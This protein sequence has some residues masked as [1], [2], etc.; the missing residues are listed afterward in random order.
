MGSDCRERRS[1]LFSMTRLL[2]HRWLAMSDSLLIIFAGILLLPTILPMLSV[3]WWWVR[4]WDFPR[5]QLAVLYVVVMVLT[6]ALAGRGWARLAVLGTLAMGILYQFS[7]IFPYLPFAS[8]QTQDATITD[9]DFSIRILTANVLMTNRSSQKFLEIVGRA[10][11]DLLIIDEPDAWWAEQLRVL[12]E[13]F[14]YS[15]KHP[16]DNT[17]GMIVYS[18]LPMLRSEVRFLLDKEIPSIHS[19]LRLRSGN[20]IEVIAVHPRPPLPSID[21]GE[22]DVELILVGRQ[23][24]ASRYASIIAG[25]LNDVGWSQTTQVFQKVSGLLDPR[26]GRGLYAT[27]HADYPFLRYPLDHL[28]HA[29]EFRLRHMEVLEHFGSDHF[30]LL[31]ELMYE[32]E[33]QGEQDVPQMDEQDHEQA[34]EKVEQVHKERL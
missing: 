18:R 22:R 1:T 31:M 32:P 30:P 5:V 27:F 13:S 23:A 20:L 3:E 26:K 7:W 33:R 9:K 8:I 2:G 6:L 16:L 11:P 25:D 17:Y 28:F 14:P 29:A 10:S 34:D 19:L 12:D 4:M 15:T 24:K 21:T